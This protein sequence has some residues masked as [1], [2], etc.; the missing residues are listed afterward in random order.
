MKG[1]QVYIHSLGQVK[2]QIKSI[3]RDMGSATKGV[4]IATSQSSS[5]SQ[6]VPTDLYK[7]LI[8]ESDL[9]FDLVTMIKVI[10]FL[11]LVH[12]YC[13]YHL[14]KVRIRIFKR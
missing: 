1:L 10:G 14:N 9:D 3:S 11:D 8:L 2:V 13:T 4:L 6:P 7:S 12:T 5:I